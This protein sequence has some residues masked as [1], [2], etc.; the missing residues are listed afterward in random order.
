MAIRLSQGVKAESDATQSFQMEEPVKFDTKNALKSQVMRRNVPSYR[1]IRAYSKSTQQY[2][3]ERQRRRKR[4][5]ATVNK[6]LTFGQA[7]RK[8]GVSTKTIQ[9]DMA[10]LERYLKGQ[11]NRKHYLL[12]KEQRERLDALSTETLLER[13]RM[14]A[15][16]MFTTRK[17]SKK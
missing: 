10:K 12:E 15:N 6:G 7:A 16:L 1:V 2:Q 4:H 5:G 11:I 8:L 13:W 14:L 17:L 9:R 3:L